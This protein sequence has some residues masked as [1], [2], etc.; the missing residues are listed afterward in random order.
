MESDWFWFLIEKEV[1]FIGTLFFFLV[2]HLV[3]EILTKSVHVFQMEPLR[4]T[5][6]RVLQ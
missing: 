1:C 4:R 2:I 3:L 6:V 5:S